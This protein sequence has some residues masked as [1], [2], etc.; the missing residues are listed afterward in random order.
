MPFCVNAPASVFSALKTAVALRGRRTKRAA[1]ALP[2]ASNSSAHLA[3]ASTAS[4]R[5][6]FALAIGYAHWHGKCIKQF[7]PKQVL[8]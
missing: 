8:C 6:M 2:L 3:E 5:L 7:S 4:V 1:A